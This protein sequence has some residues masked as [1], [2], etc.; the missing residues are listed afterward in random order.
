MTETNIWND[1]LIL[2]RNQKKEGDIELVWTGSGVEF[3]MNASELGLEFESGNSIYM[4]WISVVLDGEWLAHIPV[5]EGNSRIM[6]FRGMYSSV[7][8]RVRITKDTQASV[9]DPGSFLILKK[10][11][12]EGEVH[13]PSSKKYKFEFIGDSITSGEGA[14]GAHEEM[15]WITPYFSSVRNYAVMTSDALDAEF[16]I[17]SQSGWGVTAGW[18]N[19]PTSTLP[20]LYDSV[21]AKRDVKDYDHLSWV[22]DAVIINLGTN[23]CGAFDNPAFTDPTTGKTY[24]YNKLPDGKLDPADLEKIENGIVS[25][26]KHLR[27]CH[28]QAHLLW[29][30]GMLGSPLAETIEAAVSRFWSEED[31]NANFLLLPDTTGEAFGSRGHPGLLSHRASSEKIVEKLK[32]ILK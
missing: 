29:V 2:G 5:Q 7:T 8:H 24:K 11:I 22:P 15:D 30:Y 18:D 17:L 13:K 4:S 12:F 6:L 28:P 25:F 9:D 21:F 16:R 10:L 26:M 14:L 32:D 23:D 19:N 20:L 27:K 31:R 3:D 1:V